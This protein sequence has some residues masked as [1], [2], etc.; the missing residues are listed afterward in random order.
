MNKEMIERI[1]RALWNIR[2]EDDDR[3]DMELEGIPRTHSVWKEA[4]IA[5]IDAERGKEAVALL[6]SDGYW[7]IAKSASPDLR[8]RLK[9]F[10]C[11]V[12][13]FLSP[14]IPEG[15]ALVPIDPS[16]MYLQAIRDAISY[17]KRISADEAGIVHQAVIAAAQGI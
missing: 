16:A 1:A 12:P 10:G 5:R 2:R 13:V 6:H 3:C 11:R 9:T 8:E 15:M 14:T 7:T 4:A 17:A